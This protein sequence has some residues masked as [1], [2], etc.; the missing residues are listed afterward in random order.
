[1]GIKN[2]NR[3]I[4]LKLTGEKGGFFI[5]CPTTG[6]KPYIEI[7]GQLFPNGI[8]MAFDVRLKNL[9]SS[10]VLTD[11][12]KIEVTAG[13]EGQQSV[14]F[15]GS[16]TNVYTESPG[17]DRVTVIQCTT[18]YFSDWINKTC[19]FFLDTGFTLSDALEKLTSAAGYDQPV[20]DKTITETSKAPFYAGPYIHDAI[21]ELNALFPDVYISVNDNKFTAKKKGTV[22]K[23]FILT[24][25]SCTPAISAEGVTITAPW[26]PQVR[27]GDHLRFNAQYRTTSNLGDIGNAAKVDNTLTIEV[28]SIRFQFSTCGNSNQMIVQ[29]TITGAAE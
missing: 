13:Y 18:S 27:P 22:L 20:I 17:P 8:V 15:S 25:L 4:S 19:D 23:T 3:I 24:H 1:M 6:R 12:H 29:G 5:D 2:Y 16:V 9:Y 11:Y 21:K 7:S 10:Q 14:A 26:E 28:L